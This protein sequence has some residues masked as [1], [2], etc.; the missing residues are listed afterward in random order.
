MS[1]ITSSV[2]T[3]RRLVFP[4]VGLLWLLG[5]LLGDVPRPWLWLYYIPAPIIAAWG[6][7]DWAL[8]IHRAS[9]IRSGF[10]IAITLLAL[11]KTLLIDSRW[12][13]PTPPPP[14]AIRVVHWNVAHVP[15]GYAPLLRELA[16]EHPDL[17]IFVEARYSDDLPAL[18]ETELGLPHTFQ[19]QGMIVMSR[20]PF[21]PQGT[22]RVPHSRAWWARV[23]T[24]RGPLDILIADILSHP[25]LDRK[26]IFEAL[27]RWI[28]NRST[29]EPLLLVGDLNT[30]RDNRAMKTLRAQ[31]HH[32]YEIGGRG[33]PYSW[34]R[35][36]SV[37]AIDHAWVSSQIKV[38]A[39]RLR[40]SPLS[41]H[42]LQEFTI[43]YPGPIRDNHP[44]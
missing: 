1:L 9:W 12:N 19:D 15:F 41:D 43:S 27:L 31:L 8:R 38:H 30:T 35:P 25:A 28:N 11:C 33:W 18:V 23:E 3:A 34:P 26:P 44:R 2:R 42:R 21:E 37:Y 6:V 36:F 14:D 5:W 22:I 39:Y 17:V 7:I 13:R 29:I 16:P 24:P 4:C 20:Y 40:S 32:A 10:T